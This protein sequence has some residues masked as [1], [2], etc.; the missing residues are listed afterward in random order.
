[1]DAKLLGKRIKLARVELDM[2]Q[3]DLADSIGETKKHFS[4]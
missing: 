2:N 1:M 4:I 3:A